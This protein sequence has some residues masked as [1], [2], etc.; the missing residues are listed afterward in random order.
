MA[1]K[2][3]T[4]DQLTQETM[5]H[6]QKWLPVLASKLT[7]AGELEP[8][9]RSAARRTL[10]AEQDKVKQGMHPLEAYEMKKQEWC[11]LN[12]RDWNEPEPA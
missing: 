7:A 1:H 11:F 4:E 6:W 3:P 8:R 2:L 5:E 9:A 12:P 10:E